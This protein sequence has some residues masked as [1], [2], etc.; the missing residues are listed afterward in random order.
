M[1]VIV[2]Q[3]PVETDIPRNHLTHFCYVDSGKHYEGTASTT[4]TGKSCMNWSDAPSRYGLDVS[5]IFLRAFLSIIEPYREY[6]VNRY[7][8]LRYGKNYCRNPGGKKTKPW[9]YSEPMGQ[10]E[11]CDVRVWTVYLQA[12]RFKV[13]GWNSC[14]IAL[15]LTRKVALKHFMRGSYT[16]SLLHLTLLL[17]SKVKRCHWIETSLNPLLSLC[18]LA[19]YIPFYLNVALR[20]RGQIFVPLL[21]V[22]MWYFL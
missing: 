18:I 7:P 10:E 2:I 6:N 12:L 5:R 22:L 16:P 14:F 1:I 11:Y 19:F 20:G 21:T 13:M 9:C 17:P 15:F 4:V 3:M 8:E